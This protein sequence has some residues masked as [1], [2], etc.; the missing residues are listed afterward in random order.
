LKEDLKTQARYVKCGQS[1]NA[2]H[3]FIKL[4][5]V[6]EARSLVKG[7]N[8]PGMIEVNWKEAIWQEEIKN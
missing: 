8:S 5:R 2:I 6:D 4:K 3:V 1:E 7:R